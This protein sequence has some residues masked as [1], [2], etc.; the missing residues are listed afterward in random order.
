MSQKH[1]FEST[2]LR[3]LIYLLGALGIASIVCCSDDIPEIP[4]V[5]DRVF[6]D[7][8]FDDHEELLLYIGINANGC[9]IE[10]DKHRIDIYAQRTANDSLVF[11]R[12][13]EV[14]NYTLHGMRDTITIASISSDELLPIDEYLFTTVIYD[15]HRNNCGEGTAMSG[16]RVIRWQL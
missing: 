11:Y 13:S 2:L 1:T 8:S 12:E 16:T 7:P 6:I 9:A 14:G 5:N 15:I 3:W 10:L 4:E